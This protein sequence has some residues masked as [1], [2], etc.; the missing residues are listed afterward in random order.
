MDFTWPIAFTVVASVVTILAFIYKFFKKDTTWQQPVND[1]KTDM[2]GV[3]K[4]VENLQKDNEKMSNNMKQ[5]LDRFIDFI[6]NH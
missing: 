1:L 5:L 4:D 2:T 3:K 6:Q